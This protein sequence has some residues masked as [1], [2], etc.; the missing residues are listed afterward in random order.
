MA[1][2]IGRKFWVQQ[3]PQCCFT[4]ATVAPTPSG[5]FAPWL[6]QSRIRAISRREGACRP[7]ACARV[8]NAGHTLIEDARR[9]IA[10]LNDNAGLATRKSGLTGIQSQTRQLDFGAV[11]GITIRGK[12]GLDVA[13]EI[14]R[15]GAGWS[16]GLANIH[17][18]AAST[19]P[20]TTAALTGIHCSADR[21]G[22]CIILF[23]H[24]T[25]DVCLILLSD[26]T[27]LRMSRNL[28]MNP[29]GAFPRVQPL[30]RPTLSERVAREIATMISTGESQPG[31]KLA[32]EPELCRALGVGRSTVR[33]A[34][35]CLIFI[36]MLKV[37]AGE[38]TFVTEGPTR[39]FDQIVGHGIFSTEKDIS[40]LVHTR[41]VL[42]SET[43]SLC[44]KFAHRQGFK[45][46]G[47]SAGAD[48]QRR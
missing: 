41:L 4:S 27:I 9:G 7:W 22:L 48:G 5:Q 14:D 3:K 47:R 40:D 25:S 8:A 33:E 17:P 16:W 28:P 39:M 37:R 42:E 26:L 6:I 43:A 10:R 34:V 11:T 45:G 31:Q 38:G 24:Q 46:V 21:L 19:P 20:I 36:G 2:G 30:T 12:D 29:A 23:T 44:A 1:A 35:A 18:D 13:N 32:P 15:G